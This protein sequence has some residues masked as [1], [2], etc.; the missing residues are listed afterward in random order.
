M[1]DEKEILIIGTGP[2]L[3]EITKEIADKYTTIAFSQS[4][5][6]LISE[7]QIFPDYWT[8]F[9]PNS[10]FI[11]KDDI[12]NYKMEMKNKVTI[13][14]PDLYR[15]Y[16]DDKF[17]GKFTT[18]ANMK[19]FNKLM[20]EDNDYCKELFHLTPDIIDLKF[21][22]NIPYNINFHDSFKILLHDVYNIDKFAA[23]ILPMVFYLFRNIE[24][25][26]SIGFGD[27]TGPR[28]NGI[29]CKDYPHYIKS[30]DFFE[31]YFKE[32]LHQN[33]IDIEFLEGDRSYFNKL[34]KEE[35][36]TFTGI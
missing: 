33:S 34:N 32:Y 25:I 3:K 21:G 30:F 13:I 4:I 19:N 16:V 20:Y 28:A 14:I 23:F 6:Y 22:N 36:W 35:K 11:V 15:N 18:R 29:M 27:F 8:F 10:Y 31:S 1:I 7:N 5:G 2:T 17:H 9:D 26:Y 12:D 24:T